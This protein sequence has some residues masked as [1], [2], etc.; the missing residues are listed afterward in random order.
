MALKF[1]D[2]E[3]SGSTIDAIS[4]YNYIYKAQSLGTNVVAVNDSW[5]GDADETEDA[6]KAVIEMV[7]KKGHFQL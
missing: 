5:G 2:E 1:L 7:G 6:L 4:A 3:G